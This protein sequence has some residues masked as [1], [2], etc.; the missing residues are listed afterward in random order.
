MVSVLWLCVLCDQAGPL[1]VDP[2]RDWLDY[3]SA[4][5]GL[6]GAL[7]AAVAILYAARLSA[8][9]KRDLSRERR[10]EFE[11]ELL[12]EIRRQMSITKFQHLAGYVGAL[13]RDAH[14]ETD[15]AVLR[16]IVGTKSGPQ[17]RQNRDD[18]RDHAKAQS[19]DVQS[20]WLKVAAAEIDA[21]IDRRLN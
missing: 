10:L 14:E 15:L 16:A 7:L 6:V 2:V 5:S 3:V 12:A 1:P 17:G 8:Q 21:A 18:I 4:F 13:I 11:L 9:A 20:E 19:Q